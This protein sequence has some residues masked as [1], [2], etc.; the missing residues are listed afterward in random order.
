MKN[1]QKAKGKIEVKRASVYFGDGQK[2]TLPEF[3]VLNRKAIKAFRE[4]ED[5]NC[6]T[7][8]LEKEGR[9]LVEHNL[10]NE[11]AIWRVVYGILIWCGS[12]GNRIRGQIDKDAETRKAVIHAVRRSVECLQKGNMNGAVEA[13]TKP[14]GLSVSFGSKILRILAP[15]K[16]GVYDEILSQALPYPKN[17]EGWIE[18]CRDCKKVTTELKKRRIKNSLRVNGTWFV[19]DVEA[20]ILQHIRKSK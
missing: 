6:D 10:G 7:F 18:F 9:Y 8:S 16:I 20:I 5:A 14:N 2:I 15:K 11:G 1:K 4:K 3:P 19:A 17:N 13:I 12:S